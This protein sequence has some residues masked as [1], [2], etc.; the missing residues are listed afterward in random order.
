[1]KKLLAII[2]LGL[3][4]SG[5]VSA[6]TLEKKRGNYI[7]NNLSF[8]YNECQHYFMIMSEAIRTNNPDPKL[9]K[10]YVDNS[11]LV[12]DIAFMYGEDANMSL[13]GMLAR[14][15]QISDK[16]LKSLSNNFA[17]IAVLQVKYADLC[18]G[19]VESP[20]LRN[21]YWINKANK[22]YP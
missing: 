17:N 22:K 18:K 10:N 2:V 5:N 6:E 19:L 1:M 13:D 9:I 12:G 11:K 16:M 14:S 15:K 21:Q 7:Y 8:E 4:F 3:L 20:E